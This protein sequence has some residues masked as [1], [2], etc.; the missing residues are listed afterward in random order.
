MSEHLHQNGIFGWSSLHLHMLIILWLQLN[1]L[2]FIVASKY[3][4]V[5]KNLKAFKPISF[6]V[7]WTSNA[8]QIW[9]SFVDSSDLSAWKPHYT[10]NLPRFYS[11]LALTVYWELKV[12]FLTLCSLVGDAVN[13]NSFHD[14]IQI[15][16]GE[17]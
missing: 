11:D 4:G 9:L 1:Q 2:K 15:T 5:I 17:T 3:M 7:N 8:L 14:Q 13:N 16:K 6:A 12:V 10:L